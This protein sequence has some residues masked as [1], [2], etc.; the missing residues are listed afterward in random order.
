VRSG[1]GGWVGD[2]RFDKLV[3]ISSPSSASSRPYF[4]LF[5]SA[6]LCSVLFYPVLSCSVMS[7]P[8]LPCSALV[9]STLLP[10]ALFCNSIQSSSSLPAHLFTPLFSLRCNQGGAATPILTSYTMKNIRDMLE[11]YIRHRHHDL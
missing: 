9:C 2:G 10:S 1:P 6:M 11:E 3:P 5:C 7:C 4:A 8:V